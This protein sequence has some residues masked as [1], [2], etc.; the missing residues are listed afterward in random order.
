MKKDE[1]QASYVLLG[2][3]PHGGYIILCSCGAVEVTR[4]PNEWRRFKPCYPKRRC[5]CNECGS[6]FRMEIHEADFYGIDRK[7]L[8]DAMADPGDNNSSLS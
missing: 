7:A 2:A 1:E 5:H 8:L 4:Q 6:T 3:G